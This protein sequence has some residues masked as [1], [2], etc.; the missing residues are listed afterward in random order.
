MRITVLG[1]AGNMGATVARTLAGRADL[2]VV[3]ADRE[4]AA[5]RALASQLK[6][7][8]SVVDVVNTD[9]LVSLLDETDI[10]VNCIGPF[11]RYAPR[12]C[13]AAVR[14]GV[15]YV[16]ICDDAEPT[17]EMLT[18]DS[19]ARRTG[20]SAVI[21]CGW[22]PGI[23]NVCAR[24]GTEML[25]SAA[26]VEITW[27]A[28]ES[29]VDP[30]ARGGVA[31]EQHVLHMLSHPVT[32]FWDG[33]WAT[34]SPLAADTREI[35]APKPLGRVRAYVCGHPEP[36]TLPRYLPHL[37][38]VTVRGV[39]KP[40]AVDQIYSLLVKLGAAESDEKMAEAGRL[41]ADL[42]R[43]FA[44]DGRANL[45]PYSSAVVEVTGTKAGKQATVRLSCVDHMDRLTG[46]PAAVAA[47]MIADGRAREAGV[48]PPEA[49]FIP[50]EFLSELANAG[51]RVRQQ[52][53]RSSDKPPRVKVRTRT[54]GTQAA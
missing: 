52:L 39:I 8:A 35:V 48:R 18:F 5:A 10:V 33:D 30:E 6:V 12:I 40:Q 19:I 45:P 34:V 44:T 14:R 47:L 7:A 51:I 32:V 3:V 15:H 11:F 37:R 31:V 4:E 26:D 22:T 25:D 9:E 27:V 53:R 24:L 28:S 36:V 46:I 17:L 23:T 50:Q 54:R 41:L 21:G 2:E 38:N 1:G 43:Y 29:D 16:D 42:A 49:A 13:L 20:A